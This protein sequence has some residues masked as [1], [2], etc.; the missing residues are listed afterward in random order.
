MSSVWR[1]S[2]QTMVPSKLK[3][4]L[5]EK[6]ESVAHKDRNFFAFESTKRKAIKFHEGF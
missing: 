6:H 5:E 2:N 4:H 3:R 1:K